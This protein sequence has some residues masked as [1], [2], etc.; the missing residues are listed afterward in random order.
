MF[1]CALARVQTRTCR[2]GVGQD[3]AAT[4]PGVEPSQ[5]PL[6]CAGL[7]QRRHGVFAAGLLAQLLSHPADG[8]RQ[9]RQGADSAVQHGAQPHD[10][11]PRG[12]QLDRWPDGHY[13]LCRVLE[14]LNQQHDRRRLGYDA[15]HAQHRDGEQPDA[16]W[17]HGLAC[18]EWHHWLVYVAVASYEVHSLAYSLAL[19]L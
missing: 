5:E 13:D 6:R 19:A 1:V 12:Q 9:D 4:T 7:E 3:L 15:L 16:D 11:G 8:R 2:P 10:L 17:H 14:H 18:V